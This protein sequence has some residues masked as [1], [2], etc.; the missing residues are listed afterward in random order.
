MG[1]TR[2]KPLPD[3]KAFQCCFAQ[4][5]HLHEID[6]G[7]FRL[8]MLCMGL[9]LCFRS[10]PSPRRHRG[11]A[12]HQTSI[13]PGTE[14]DH[15]IHDD[16]AK[17]GT[18]LL[19]EP[20][21]TCCEG[22]P[23]LWAVAHGFHSARPYVNH[24]A[25]GLRYGS[26]PLHARRHSTGGQSCSNKGRQPNAFIP[27][28]L[29]PSHHSFFETLLLYSPFLLVTASFKIDVAVLPTPNIICHVPCRRR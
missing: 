9:I 21:K 17:I 19:G 2:Q 8:I 3:V 22:N 12:P 20:H 24:G 5:K 4:R 23:W 15:S 1:A 16:R 10:I 7:G 29:T 27:N 6:N 13:A 18:E 14:R 25:A 28:A 26:D 11:S